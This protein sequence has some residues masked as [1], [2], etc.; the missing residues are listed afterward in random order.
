MIPLVRTARPVYRAAAPKRNAER[1]IVV[2]CCDFLNRSDFASDHLPQDLLYVLTLHVEALTNAIR[3]VGGTLNSIR[4]DSVGALFGL[5]SRPD[6]AAQQALYA[7]HVI[8]GLHPSSMSGWVREHDS[9]M[10]VAISVHAGR[11]AFGEVGSYDPPMVMA[12]GE[13]VDAANEMRA[14]AAARGKAFAIS[15]LGLHR[16][17]SQA[18][19][20][21]AKIEL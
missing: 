8:E 19:V 21:R 2:L 4:P 9:R 12:V 3:S 14:V 11:A 18:G 20:R 10:K 15:E 16:S 6:L 5:D 7:A 1:T 13:A 17:R